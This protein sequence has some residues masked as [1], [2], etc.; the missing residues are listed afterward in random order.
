M[1]TMFAGL[2]DAKTSERGAFCHPGVYMVRVRKALMKRTRKNYDAFILEFTIED[3]TYEADKA[4]LVKAGGHTAAAEEALPNKVG[5]TASWFQSLADQDIGYGA[6]KSFAAAVQGMDVADKE[7][8][9]GV[10]EF[11][12]AVVQ[13]NALEGVLIPLEVITIKTKSGGD[14]SLYKW[15]EVIDEKS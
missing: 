9:A 8:V 6:L 14:F 4:A 13:N 5:S 15:S 12:E 10:E 7:F 3:S 2:K 1:G 11:L